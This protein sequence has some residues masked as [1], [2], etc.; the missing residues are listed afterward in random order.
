MIRTIKTDGDVISR[1]HA[2]LDTDGVVVLEGLVDAD[3]LSALSLDL[4]PQLTSAEPAGGSFFGR[5]TK[6]LSSIVARSDHFG[7][8]VTHP[9]LLGLA[10]AVLGSNCDRIQ[11]QVTGV[12]EVWPGGELQPLHRDVDVYSPYL[13]VPAGG[14]EHVLSLMIALSEFTPANGGTHFVLGSHRRDNAAPTHDDTVQVAMSPGSVA[15]WM[16]STLH[17]LGVNHTDLPRTGVVSGYSVG[18]LRQE[19]NQYLACPPDVAAQLPETV[20][21]LVGY[22]THSPMLGW[23]ERKDR[24][25]L[26][27]PAPPRRSAAV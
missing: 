2:I 27:R 9:S 12:L 5:R 7:R 19:E 6:R 4:A 21:Q 20:Q 16:G 11:L 24:D 26:L 23:V 25:N 17:G 1:A 15:V 10:D 13:P 8:V 18:W 3:T 22:Q 14:P